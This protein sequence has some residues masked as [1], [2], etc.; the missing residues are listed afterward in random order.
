MLV[1]FANG[2]SV[3]AFDMSKNPLTLSYISPEEKGV[4]QL[5][6]SFGQPLAQNIYVYAIGYV[7][8]TVSMDRSRSVILNFLQNN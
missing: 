2:N 5:S 8:A 1:D 4:T 6:L 3:I 7:A